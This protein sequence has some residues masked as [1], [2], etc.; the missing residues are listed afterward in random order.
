[1][2]KTALKSFIR[3]EII[4]V[5]KE[6]TYAGKEAKADITKDP[7]FNTLAADAK[8]SAVDSL[9]KGGSVTLEEDN[10]DELARIATT[11]KIGDKEKA[12]SAKELYA[13]KWKSALIDAVEKAGDAGISQPD[14]A[15]ALGKGSQQ[16]IN[17]TVREFITAGV[18][19]QG[20]AKIAKSNEEPKSEKKQKTV[21]PAKAS[22]PKSEPKVEKDEEDAPE[23]EDTYYKADEEDNVDTE[24]EP[25][26]ADIKAVEK[27]LGKS[28][29]SHAGK[30]SPEDE[31][32]L[33]KLKAGIKSKVAKL[34]K[35]KKAD[36]LKSDDLKVLKTLINRDDV[37]KIFKQ[38]GVSLKDLVS[39]V[40][41][42]STNLNESQEVKILKGFADRM[43]AGV[44]K[45]KQALKDNGLV[46]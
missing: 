34:S 4:S 35:M 33:D 24:K 15:T 12:N 11:I 43:E 37:K 10:L 44:S 23:V 17:P 16:A 29:A 22:K 41:A 3:E 42:E 9:G 40:I 20:E 26:V 6:E 19:T 13:G 32:R 21:K 14:L 46:K 30:L 18:L 28:T 27:T 5:L 7:K 1:M 45:F 38:K 25:K 36:R 8:K 39:D 31:A 2:K